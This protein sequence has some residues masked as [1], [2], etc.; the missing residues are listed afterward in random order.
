M[1]ID[2]V[3]EMTILNLLALVR[4]KSILAI[5][6]ADKTQAVMDAITN[7]KRCR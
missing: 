2:E 1:D 4:D 3:D 7:G 6:K 5:N